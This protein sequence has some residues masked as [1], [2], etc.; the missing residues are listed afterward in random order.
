[1]LVTAPAVVVLVWAERAGER[2]GWAAVLTSLTEGASVGREVYR[3]SLGF[4]VRRCS[5]FHFNM[6][7]QH[8][9]TTHIIRSS[10]SV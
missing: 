4:R 3:S 1:M 2:E 10:K 9:Q 6:E 7:K 8:H 5:V